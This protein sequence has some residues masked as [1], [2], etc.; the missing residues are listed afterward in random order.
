MDAAFLLLRGALVSYA[1]G[2]LAAIVPWRRGG[3]G[4]SR[5]AP[6]L[7][8]LGAA[9]HTGALFATSAAVGRC[10][11]VTLPEVLSALAWMLTLAALLVWWR[12][13]LD[14]V[15]AIE[16]PV[17]ALVLLLAAVLPPAALPPGAGLPPSFLRFHLT[18]ILFGV[19]ALSITFAASLMYLVVDR[20]L[21][22]KRPIA[23][24]RRL[25][26]LAACDRLAYRSLGVAFGLLTLGILS[27]A[28]INGLETGRPWTWR[29]E[30][31]L[32]ILAWAL[33]GTIVLARLGWGWRG[34]RASLLMV[35]GFCLVLLRMLGL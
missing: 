14:A 23:A 11:L 32:A 4:P 19:T 29:P 15:L 10:P 18:V 9:L 24:F 20:A 13:R 17:A 7:A 16:L 8:G 28:V 30:E 35:I 21:K 34:R 1:A 31:T 25:P 27:G 26:S 33:L 22:A 12:S 6:G 3:K 5:L 2:S